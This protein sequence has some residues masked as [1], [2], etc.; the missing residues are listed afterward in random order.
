MKR[1][2]SLVLA[3]LLM[4]CAIPFA[5]AEEEV[6]TITYMWADQNTVPDENTIQ[7]FVS[8]KLG[9]NWETHL[10][11]T[12]EYD[13][14][15]NALIAANDLPDMFR[16]GGQ[17]AVELR[18]AGKLADLTPYL[19]EYGPDILK[20][21]EDAGRS[22]SDLNLNTDDA[23]YMLASNRSDYISN[24]T[25]RKDWLDNL[26]MEAPTTVDELYDVLY[27]FKFNDPDQNGEDD[28]EGWL[29]QVDQAETWEHIF[30]MYGVAYNHFMF[31]EDG[32][33]IRFIKAPGY[34]EAIKFM[35]KLYQDGIMYHDFA[36]ATWLDYVEMLWNGKL[37]VV[38]FRTVGQANNWYPG[39]YTF[40]L[41]GD[42][43]EDL[44]VCAH[45]KNPETGEETGGCM[46]Y[47]GT[48]SGMVVSA[49][50]EHPEKAVELMNYIFCTEEG[51]DLVYFGIEGVHYKWIDKENGK[52]ERIGEFADD[53]VH[54]ADGC[55]T[56]AQN[57]TPSNSE[58]RTMNAF[59]QE[60]Q[61]Y[62][63]KIAT[64]WAFIS[65]TTP[66]WS[67]YGGT[68]TTIE[69]EMM[70]NMIVSEDPIEDMYAEYLARWDAEGGLLCEEEANSF[71]E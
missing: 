21:Y 19:E 42:S 3:L 56:Y 60:T 34:L 17:T 2:A 35:R 50:C 13:L 63:R 65:A 25:F 30:A 57:W 28:T 15:L 44:F 6:P 55:F 18:D 52:Y 49:K 51:Q 10:V 29:G 23:I 11:N 66:V 14:K 7:K 20:S 53:L 12:T 45:I 41:P 69:R 67:D 40:E 33:V 43:V 62:E 47:P 71:F 38:S 26:G 22:L 4:L 54:R 48:D 16:V 5:T 39:R 36:T 8:E 61:E 46:K 59:T 70:C 31:D 58:S 27:A 1:K 32:S 37:G 9:I 68:L 64:E 24:F